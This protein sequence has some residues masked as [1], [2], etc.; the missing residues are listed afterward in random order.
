MT[1]I[2]LTLCNSSFLFFFENNLR[3]DEAKLCDSKIA[4]IGVLGSQ[5]KGDEALKVAVAVEL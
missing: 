1:L 5:E 3:G 2:F 4:L